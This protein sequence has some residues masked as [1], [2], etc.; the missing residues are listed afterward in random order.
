ME[1]K[2]KVIFMRVRLTIVAMEK[3]KHY[4]FWVCVFVAWDIQHKKHVRRVICD[5]PGYT[6]FFQIFS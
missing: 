2:Y 4:I 3:S 5:L 1:C 6:E